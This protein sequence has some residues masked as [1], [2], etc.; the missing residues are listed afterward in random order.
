MEL[1]VEQ[2]FNAYPNAIRARLYEVRALIFNVAASENIG[3][4]TETLKWGQPSY[5]SK[6]GSTL[7]ID[8]SAKNPDV[9]SLY[10]NCNTRL[11]DTFK[12]IFQHQFQYQGNRE[13]TLPL[14]EAIPYNALKSCI[15]MALRYHQIK[16]LPLLGQ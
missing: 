7:R 5:L 1:A 15:S 4:I 2:V 10:F 8:W 12:E 11:V 16:H 13:I 9:V 14:S 6:T 3:H